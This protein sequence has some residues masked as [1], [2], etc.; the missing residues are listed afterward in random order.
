MFLPVSLFGESRKLLTGPPPFHNSIEEGHHVG[1]KVSYYGPS[2]LRK[3]SG[4]F[5]HLSLIEMR[6]ALLSK[7]KFLFNVSTMCRSNL[8]RLSCKKKVF[9]ITCL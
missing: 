8:F 4:S 6:N 2:S 5:E 9:S 1:L 7:I 3:F